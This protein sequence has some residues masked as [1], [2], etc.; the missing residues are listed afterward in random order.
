M[1]R[2]RLALCIVLFL[3]CGLPLGLPLV[4]ALHDLV[5][6][7][8]AS[9]ELEFRLEVEKPAE[10][11]TP[12]G[13]S[14]IDERPAAWSL[15]SERDRF[16]ALAGNTL[17]LV[18]GT[19]ALALPAG[20]VGAIVLYR[21][22]LPGRRVLRLLI[23]LAMFVPLPVFGSGWQ[24]ALGSGGLFAFWTS[25]R[26]PWTPWD[27]GLRAAAWIHAVA[28]LPWIVWLVGLGLCWVEPELEEDAL[29]SMSPARVLWHVTLRR[30]GA[31]I[32]AAAL[33]VALQ[34]ATEVTVTDTMQVRTYAEE[35]YLQFVASD[36]ALVPRLVAVALPSILLASALVVW[37]ARRW[38]RTLPP[39]A[40]LTG[41]PRLFCLGRL[42]WP[43]FLVV[44]AFVA[45]LVCVP[46][47]SLLWKA[48]LEG[49]PERWSAA[50]LAEGLRITARARARLVLDSLML[51]ALAGC[52]T[53]LLALAASWLALES[54][55]FRYF[56]LVLMASAWAIPAPIVGVGLKKTIDLLLVA[57]PLPP[58]AV[59]LYYGPSPLPSLWVDVVR[60]FPC[61]VA[62]TWPIVRLLPPELRDAA[63]V[64]GAR[65]WQEFRQVVLPL[66]L[67]VVLF[68]ALAVA[69][70]SLGEL[71]AGKLVETPGSVTFAHELFSQMHYGTGRDVAALCLLLL[72]PVCAGS[73]AVVMAGK[74]RLRGWLGKQ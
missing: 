5:S 48:G 28:G 37:T 34:T 44:F 8:S 49:S 7:R 39:L 61:A 27:Q 54:R 62:V 15:W 23:V 18:V 56:V 58:V 41:R 35:V 32:G 1:R 2:W 57:I 70:L 25:D 40:T 42:R 67:P 64:D 45:I 17:L 72:L 33:W 66:A 3:A 51:A 65:P 13:P 29:L 16:L 19:L 38:Q 21:T 68:A 43:S 6:P 50:A 47:S 74:L 60:F 14:R 26:A 46:L 4:E 20:I 59:A 10:V 22:D 9:D 63:R 24:A 71:G 73:A 52:V 11:G 69:V 31:A 55:R 36:R 53:A 12:T 30:S